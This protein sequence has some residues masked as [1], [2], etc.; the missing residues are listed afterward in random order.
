MAEVDDEGQEGHAAQGGGGAQ[1]LH[2]QV[3]PG[4]GIDGDGHEEGPDEIV[5]DGLEHEPE[6]HADGQIAHEHRHGGRKSGAE[7]TAVHE[8]HSLVSYTVRTV[9]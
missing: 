8:K 7:G 2:P 5:S 4:A 6:G 9:V 3:L 1:Q